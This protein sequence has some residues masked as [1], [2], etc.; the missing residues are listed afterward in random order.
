MPMKASRTAAALDS[1][2]VLPL[3]EQRGAI[4]ARRRRPWG[5][6]LGAETAGTDDEARPAQTGVARA[7]SVVGAGGALCRRFLRRSTS[8]SAPRGRFC[9]SRRTQSCTAPP[10]LA[11][12]L[13]RRSCLASA[14][15]VPL[16]LL[17]GEPPADGR[18]RREVVPVDARR[19]VPRVVE[20]PAREP[21]G[22]GECVRGI[23]SSVRPREGL[24][25]SGDTRRSEQAHPFPAPRAH[26]PGASR[27]R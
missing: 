26:R 1:V 10:P 15:V 7:G 25:P 8:T 22:A 18:P 23:G 12:H 2:A 4:A 24:L 27:S 11:E 9:P 17:L 6:Y 16:A 5:S 14:S 13:Q 21:C 3:T 20:G 19:G